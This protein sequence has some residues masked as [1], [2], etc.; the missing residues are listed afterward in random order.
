MAAV[1]TMDP[2]IEIFNLDVIDTLEP[3]AYLGTVMYT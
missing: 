3:V 2:H 1:G